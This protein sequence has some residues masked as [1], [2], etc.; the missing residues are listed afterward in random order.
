MVGVKLIKEFEGCSLRSYP[1]PKTGGAPITIG[2]GS[3]RRRDGTGFIMGNTIT[4][5]E[6]D[7]LL[8]YDIE[9]RFLPALQ[10]IPYWNEMNENQQGA[11]LSFAY[12]LGANFYGSSNFNTITK[13]LKNKEWNKVPDALYLYRNPG[14]NVEV[15]LARR[16]KAEGQLWSNI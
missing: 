8:C 5:M 11:L 12:N 3:T 6:A 9:T 7:D 4:Q 2:W 1:D 16:R 15:G 14:S 10:K 13:V